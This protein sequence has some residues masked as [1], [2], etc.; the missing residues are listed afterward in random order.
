M[1]CRRL[2]LSPELYLRRPPAKNEEY[3]LDRL[4]K[5]KAEEGVKIY[6][7][8]YKKFPK[9]VLMTLGIHHEKII[10]VDRHT[11]FIGGFGF[12]LWSL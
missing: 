3:R 6:V 8:V 2:V 11:S 7:V 10:V 4:L 12:V 9:L 1:V 5:K